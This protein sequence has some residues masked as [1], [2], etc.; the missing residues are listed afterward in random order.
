MKHKNYKFNTCFLFSFIL[1]CVPIL[2]L[3][4]PGTPVTV[5]MNF[6]TYI[7]KPITA[8]IITVPDF[9]KIAVAGSTTGNA[10]IVLSSTNTVS[11]GTNTLSCPPQPSSTC[12]AFLSGTAVTGKLGISGEASKNIKL[13]APSNVIFNSNITL[14]PLINNNS[15]VTCTTDASGNCSTLNLTGVLS[16]TNVDVIPKQAYSIP[17]VITM[18]YN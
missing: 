7:Y 13:T 2:V 1:W 3:A 15:T 14:T 16:L 11:L 17:V 4:A 9:G 8:N 6:S 10:N 12:L 18:N 5:P